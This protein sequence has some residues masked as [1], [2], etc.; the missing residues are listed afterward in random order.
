ME[1]VPIDNNFN[2]VADGTTQQTF[3]ATVGG[4]G[5][6]I[7]TGDATANANGF[8]EVVLPA[9]VECKIAFI[10]VQ[11]VTHTTFEPMDECYPF[12]W[13]H[14]GVEDGYLFAQYG[15]AVR[16]AKDG[17]SS[18]GFVKAVAD[19]KIVVYVEA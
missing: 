13:S 17:G 12:E 3:R 9:G 18:L 16:I 11:A 5:A 19:K 8:H 6:D 1:N 14:D 7:V 4:T 15:K 2:V 10:Q